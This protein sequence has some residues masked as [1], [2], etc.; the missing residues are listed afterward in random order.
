MSQCSYHALYNAQSTDR[1]D[2]PTTV[3]QRNAA[4]THVIC[5][6]SACVCACVRACLFAGLVGWLVACLLTNMLLLLGVKK[7]QNDNGN[8]YRRERIHSN[9]KLITYTHTFI[10]SF[11]HSFILSFFLSFFP[12]FLPSFNNLVHICHHLYTGYS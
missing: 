10:H 5:S 3:A 7:M 11:I 9:S 12:S 2:E 6:V 1:T 8:V 4:L